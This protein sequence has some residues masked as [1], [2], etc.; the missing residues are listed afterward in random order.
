M[1]P[2][3][4]TSFHQTSLL[5]LL[6]RFEAPHPLL[7]HSSL[8]LSFIQTRPSHRSSATRNIDV[9]G[10]RDWRLI[11]ENLRSSLR[12]QLRCVNRFSVLQSSRHQPTAG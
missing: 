5:L 12:L 9:W 4:L 6:L 1:L 10:R 11:P 7:I 2:S 3:A 8:L